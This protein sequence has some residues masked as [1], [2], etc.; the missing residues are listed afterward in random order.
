MRLA[1]LLDHT[2]QPNA[3]LKQF[4]DIYSTRPGFYVRHHLVREKDIADMLQ[5][6]QKT[7]GWIKPCKLKL[8]TLKVLLS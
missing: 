8:T 4:R 1:Q 7:V 3:H 6:T 2:D 5:I